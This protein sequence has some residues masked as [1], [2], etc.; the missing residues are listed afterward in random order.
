MFLLHV[1]TSKEIY[2]LREGGKSEFEKIFSNSSANKHE[3]AEMPAHLAEQIEPPPPP[4]PPTQTTTN[5]IPAT[6]AT[7]KKKFNLF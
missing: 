5:P 1:M 3:W 2:D 6:P 4:V 7:K